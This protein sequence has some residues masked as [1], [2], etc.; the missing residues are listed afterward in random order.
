MYIKGQSQYKIIDTIHK[1][2]PMAEEQENIPIEI[3]IQSSS[4][5]SVAS[6]AAA[7]LAVIPENVSIEQTVENIKNPNKEGIIQL[8]KYVI[9]FY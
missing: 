7:S 1:N 9:K 3:T 6:V 4:T 5:P 8:P 2:L